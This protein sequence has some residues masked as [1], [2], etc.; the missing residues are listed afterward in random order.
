MVNIEKAGNLCKITPYLPELENL[1]TYTKKERVTEGYSEELVEVEETVYFRDGA[2]GIFP[3]GLLPRVQRYLRATHTPYT[4]AR[5]DRPFPVP[6][7]TKVEPLRD[8]QDRV[9]LALA[10]HEGGLLV[11]GCGIGKSF[12]TEQVCRMY[13]TLQILVTSPRIAVVKQLYENISKKL[14]GEKVGL[15]TGAR[16]RTGCR[17]TV[18][19][20]KSMLKVSTEKIDL[21]L[22]DEVHAVGSNSL[23]VSVAKFRNARCFGFTASPSRADGTGMVMEAM[24][25]PVLAEIPYV[26]AVEK[27]LVVPIDVHLYKVTGSLDARKKLF[28]QKRWNYWRNDTRN[29]M[30]AAVASRAPADEQTLIMV[31]TLEHA[32]ALKHRL[33]EYQVVHY[34]NVRKGVLLDGELSDN[35]KMRQRELDEIRQAF[36]RGE[37][38]KA[39]ATGTWSTGVSFDQLSLLIRADGGVTDVV[40]TQIPGRLSRLSEGKGR[41]VLV[42]FF[43]EFNSWARGRSYARLNVYRRHGWR[44]L[45]KE[46]C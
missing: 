28:A 8:G 27:R 9:L 5:H 21:L 31:D 42:D 37:L 35:F 2:C 26:E 30:V 1:L 34:G 11:G 15:L 10:G 41:G 33:P 44:L 7:F 13:P 39:V 17:V 14:P 25:G 23:A 45:Q 12:I 3:A 38:R 24:F 18:A 29:D 20:S 4:M 19:T 43:D 16:N 40:S 22:F 6:D 46:I 32:V 36:A